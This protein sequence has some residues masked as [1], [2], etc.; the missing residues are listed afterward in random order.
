MFQAQHIQINVFVYFS[1]KYWCVQKANTS[2]RDLLSWDKPDKFMSSLLTIY[3]KK[4]TR[5]VNVLYNISPFFLSKQ[6][7]LEV[8]FNFETSQLVLLCFLPFHCSIAHFTCLMKLPVL[9]CNLDVLSND[10][11]ITVAVKC[12][13]SGMLANTMRNSICK[14]HS[15]ENLSKCSSLHPYFKF[16]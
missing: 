14:E 4:S 1:V 7:L 3:S 5:N 11:S 13:L 2:C 16:S 15:Q 12:F 8:A 6:T 9:F 10:T